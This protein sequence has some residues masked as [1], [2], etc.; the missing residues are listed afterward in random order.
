LFA[1]AGCG[2]PFEVRRKMI[3]ILV[4]RGA[5]PKRPLSGHNMM[6]IAF[7]ASDAP[8]GDLLREYGLPYG[9]R[10]MAA[11]NPLDELKAAVEKEP[12]LLQ[13]R[14]RDAYAGASPTLL[15]IALRR[16]YRE[17]S[18]FLIEAG[19]PV[20]V[21]EHEGYTLLHQA[22]LGGDPQLMR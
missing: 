1:A 22:A 15:G 4:A 7:E 11:F 6:D 18:L 8:L 14:F 20:N 16:G 13:R 19:A 2:Q 10:E 5:N 12:Q 21:L 3:K 9:P 17:A